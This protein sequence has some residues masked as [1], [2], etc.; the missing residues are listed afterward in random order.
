MTLPDPSSLLDPTPAPN[1]PGSLKPGVIF[2]LIA[3]LVIALGMAPIATPFH[4]LNLPSHVVGK[5]QRINPVAAL[6]PYG[7][8][9][10]LNPGHYFSCM[11]LVHGK[12][13]TLGVFGARE[14]DWTTAL[15]GEARA[16][17]D[18]LADA[19]TQAGAVPDFEEVGAWSR[20]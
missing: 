19:I 11:A 9:I 4:A 3:Q 8:T 20:A 2:D 5:L 13:G 15:P 6:G 7:I 14:S 16:F 10:N 18:H 1:G 12:H 17:L